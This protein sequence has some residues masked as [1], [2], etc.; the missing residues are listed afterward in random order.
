MSAAKASHTGQDGFRQHGPADVLQRVAQQMARA[1]V[2]GLPR[3]Y[4]LFHEAMFGHNPALAREL[5]AL[6]SEPA[7][8]R[9][10]ALGL[11]HRLPGHCSLSDD[12]LRN[13]AAATLTDL[14]QLVSTGV[15]QKRTFVRALETISGSIRDDEPKGLDQVLSELDFLDAAAQQMLRSEAALA[16]R[17]Q[18]GID[19][20]LAQQKAAEANRTAVLRDRLTGLP[21]QIAFLGRV[22][23]LYD[24]PDDPRDSALVIARIEQFRA[25]C[26]AY[27]EEAGARLLKRLAAIFRKTIKKNDFVARIGPDQF[28]FLFDDVNGEAA[29]VIAE[30][31]YQAVSTQLVFATDDGGENPNLLMSVGYALSDGAVSAAQLTAQAQQATA[32]AQ[33]NQRHP[34]CGY[35]PESDR[36]RRGAA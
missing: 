25:L 10:D 14:A 13:D 2:A 8:A 27:G 30:R 26:N 34:V 3:N 22:D 31:I 24:K 5:A 32:A 15:L 4:D 33:A 7:Q 35:Q 17:L 21:N 11:R 19:R 6:G 1:N 29:R 12:T 20:L 9:L 36:S 18:A 23:A 28:A 16:E